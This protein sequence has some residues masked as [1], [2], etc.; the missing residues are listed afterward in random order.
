MRKV[1]VIFVKTLAR[2]VN[3]QVPKVIAEFI[4][5]NNRLAKFEYRE[6]EFV[7]SDCGGNPQVLAILFGVLAGEKQ[8]VQKV[9]DIHF[10]SH[11][12]LFIFFDNDL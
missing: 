9:F 2:H 3:K 1:V 11:F 12:S 8:L 4:N 6:L 10:S 5:A 7:I